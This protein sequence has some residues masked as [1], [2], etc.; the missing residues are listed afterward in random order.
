VKHQLK[1]RAAAEARAEKNR[2]RPRFNISGVMHAGLLPAEIEA[3][4]AGVRAA[5]DKKLNDIRALH[6]RAKRQA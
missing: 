2:S 6:P 5:A 1:L 3:F 4:Y